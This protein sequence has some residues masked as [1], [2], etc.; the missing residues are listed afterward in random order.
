M[1]AVHGFDNFRLRALAPSAGLIAAMLIVLGLVPSMVILALILVKE[2]PPFWLVIVQ[3]AFFVL[4]ST[5]FIF[6]GGNFQA[7]G[8]KSNVDEG[9]V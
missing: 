3:I 6:V 4:A 9:G 1:P 5:T 7:M 2:P 8:E